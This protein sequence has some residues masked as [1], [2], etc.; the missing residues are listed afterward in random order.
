[1]PKGYLQ[2]S[3]TPARILDLLELDGTW[4][5]AHE[6]TAELALRWDPV[7]TNVVRR[8]ISRLAISKRIETRLVFVEYTADKPFGNI[9]Q[10]EAR[11]L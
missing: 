3:G 2:Q 8:A 11:L 1:M 10:T 4:M 5:S 9:Y 6:L 7:S